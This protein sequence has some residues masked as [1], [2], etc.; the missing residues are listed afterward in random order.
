MGLK[1]YNN[2]YQ[3]KLEWPENYVDPNIVFSSNATASY[4]PKFSTS[5]TVSNSLLYDNGSNLGLGT[6]T[7]EQK[8]HIYGSGNTRILIEASDSQ[9]ELNLRV[10][11]VTW[12]MYA[13]ESDSALYF[14]NG[15][16]RLKIESDGTVTVLYKLRL[17][18]DDSP[19]SLNG[20]FNTIKN[21]YGISDEIMLGDPDGWVTVN[22]GGTDRRIPYYA[23]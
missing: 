19:P 4:I 5:T 7:P 10:N 17:D 12:S 1:V 15:D 20:V 11:S 8:F 6:I 16:D 2:K 3:V 22:I 23:V 21:Y 9:A 14:Y 13:N 18:Q